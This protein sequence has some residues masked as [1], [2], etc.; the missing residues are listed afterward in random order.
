M[1]ARPTPPTGCTAGN[2]IAE[3]FGHRVWPS[4]SDTENA[5]NDRSRRRCPFLS[6]ATGETMQCIKRA[7][8]WKEPYGV[9]TISSDSNGL[10]QDW[11]ACPYRTLDQHFTLLESAV[12]DA[13]DIPPQA[14]ILLLPLT[15][16]HK[17]EQRARIK[18]ATDRGARVFLFTS[19]KLGGEI[20]LP[21]TNASPGAAVDMSVIEVTALD[22]DGKPIAFGKHLFYE[23]Q[24]SDF[25]GSPLHAA[26]LLR[27][28]CPQGVAAENYHEALNANVEICGTG[29]EGP[30]KANIFKRTIYQMIFKIEL[31]RETECA[32]FAIVL[33]IP[34]WDSW[35][36]HLGQP[37][38]IKSEAGET[39]FTLPMPPN[40]AKTSGERA[41]A[42]VYVFDTDQESAESPLPLKIVQRVDVSADALS[43]HAFVRASNEAIQ[44]GVIQSFRNSMIDRVRKGW[45]NR[46]GKK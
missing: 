24:T 5:R 19:Q 10:R 14:A 21:E 1:G 2:F 33:P 30:N 12:Q 15:V 36:K 25:H 31:A 32:G 43:Y 23:I 6:V 37:E 34:V 39:N 8:G 9:C 29:V 41:R 17:Q 35:L 3:W 44:R 45:E 4:V 11:I 16:L 22:I 27:D 20:E 40:A 7:S 46:L 18:A 28:A 42:T 13:Y 38:L 26:A